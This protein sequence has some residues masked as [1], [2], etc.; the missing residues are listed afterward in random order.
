MDGR[1]LYKAIRKKELDIPTIVFFDA[2]STY[3]LS[4]IHKFGRP[5]VIEKGSYQGSPPELMHLFKKMA[6]FG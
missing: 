1:E 3:E 5:A 2:V 4:E 6:Y